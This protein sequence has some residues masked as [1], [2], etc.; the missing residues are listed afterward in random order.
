[1]ISPLKGGIKNFFYR[2][3]RL[4]ASRLLCFGDRCRGG[5]LGLQAK[6]NSP[7]W[8]LKSFGIFPG[9]AVRVKLR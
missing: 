4:T 6:L 9:R 1:M 3:A 5:S 7:A 2:D 8:Q